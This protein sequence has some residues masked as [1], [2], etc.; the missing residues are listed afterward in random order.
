MILLSQ[1]PDCWDYRHELPCP[2]QQ[3]RMRVTLC[4]FYFPLLLRIMLSLAGVRQAVYHG[5]IHI[6]TLLLYFDNKPTVNLR[7]PLTG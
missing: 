5:A 4:C 7:N 3:P 2:A 1:P 6:P